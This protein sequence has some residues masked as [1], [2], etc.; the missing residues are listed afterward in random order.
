MSA[1]E[2]DGIFTDAIGRLDRAAEFAVI[3]S[4]ALE[5]LKHPKA[6]LEVS[7]PVRMSRRWGEGGPI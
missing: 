2:N 4:E 6:I 1:S 7:I 3:D 5:K